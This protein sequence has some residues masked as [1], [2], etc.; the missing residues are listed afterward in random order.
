M[1]TS[2]TAPATTTLSKTLHAVTEHAL[3]ARINRRLRKDGRF[4]RK[5]RGHS[6]LRQELG[7]YY[8]IDSYKRYVGG[9]DDLAAYAKKIGTLEPGEFLTPD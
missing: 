9:T 1:T 4:L 3:I 6:H 8:L 5:T 7:T 2:K